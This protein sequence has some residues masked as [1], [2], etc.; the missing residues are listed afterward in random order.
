[1]LCVLPRLTLSWGEA[2]PDPFPGVPAAVRAYVAVT[3][4]QY[5]GFSHATRMLFAISM[6]FVI[7]IEGRCRAR[8]GS[9]IAAPRGA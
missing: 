4:L 1:M 5:I 8:K 9:R 3:I 7:L 6:C 2:A